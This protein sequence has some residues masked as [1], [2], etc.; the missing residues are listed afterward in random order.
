MVLSA[1]DWEQHKDFPGVGSPDGEYV[2]CDYG[3]AV[4]AVQRSWAGTR[5]AGIRVCLER[6]QIGGHPPVVVLARL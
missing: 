6:A 1:T 2:N 5:A 4:V 3:G